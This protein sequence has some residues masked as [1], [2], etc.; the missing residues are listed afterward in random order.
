MTIRFFDRAL[1]G[2]AECCKNLTTEFC[3]KGFQNQAQSF[4]WAAN[5]RLTH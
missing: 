1:I 5:Y 4:E 3:L 2:R